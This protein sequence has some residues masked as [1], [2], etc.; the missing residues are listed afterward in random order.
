M[1]EVYLAEQI[2]LNRPVAIKVLHP[3]LAEE[4]GFVNRFQ[5]EARIVATLRHPNIVQVYDFD[6]NEEFGVYYMVMEYIEGPTLRE[7]LEK[8]TV[9]RQEGIRIV[10]AIAD[11][12]EYAHRR[13]M[14]HRDIKPANILFTGENQ[15]VL[16]DFGIAR[17]LS[18]TGLTASGA[19]VGTPAYMAPEIG[20]GHPGTALSDIYSLGVV[21]YQLVTGQLPFDA[22][23]PM[24][25][26]MKHIND[27]VP[28]PSQLVPDLPAGLE[29]IILKMLM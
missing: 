17:M 15:P 23:V 16:T 28:P 13:Q 14:V 6:L 8:N 9:S 1:A 12:L 18:V 26:V 2:H 22:E 4:S 25:L 20:I 11:A 3:F 24:A 5:R 27:P 7:R 29:A 10:A 19:M 21:L